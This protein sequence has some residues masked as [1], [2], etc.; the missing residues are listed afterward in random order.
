[1]KNNCNSGGAHIRIYGMDCQVVSA[2]KAIDDGMERS[3]GIRDIVIGL[4]LVSGRE[5]QIVHQ[6]GV[7]F[8]VR[9]HE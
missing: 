3:Q 7:D 5:H 4:K 2:M 8:E 6:T 1:M 9:I